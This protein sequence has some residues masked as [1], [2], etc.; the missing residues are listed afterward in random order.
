MAKLG[1]TNIGG[2]GG[3][4]SD[5][6]TVTAGKVVEGYTYV[7]ADTDD[8]IGDGAI[9]N[10]ASST[11][12]QNVTTSGSNLVTRIPNGAYITNASSGYPEI[13]TS[14]SS[15]AS[16]GGLTAA[17][18]LSGQS[19]LGV[20]GTATNDAN[21]QAQYLLTGQIAYGKN[22]TKVNGT[23]PLNSSNYWNNSLGLGL[24]SDNLYSFFPTGYYPQFDTRGSLH[25]IPID[26]L[27]SVLGVTSNKILEGQ[28]IA[29]IT[30]TAKDYSYLA[31]GQV[32]F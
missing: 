20:S 16:V 4:G 12:S 6:L 32:A 23:M 22:G 10:R 30:G 29:G 5:E 21:V 13:I 17:K 14:L 31:T 24:E 28:S 18:L 2:G 3:I 11:A 1:I 7:G 27:R 15:V 8:E 26:R 25:R 9:P 19:A